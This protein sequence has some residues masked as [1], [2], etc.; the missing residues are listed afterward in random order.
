M[1][2]FRIFGAGEWGLAVANHLASLGNTVEVFLRDEKKIDIYK[3]YRLHKNLEINF[4]DNI[5]FHN[6]NRISS[7]KTDNTII[8][9]MYDLDNNMNQRILYLL[10]KHHNS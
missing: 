2:L 9:I 7:A 5:S 4:N 6:I 3:T 8:N 1:S 10:G